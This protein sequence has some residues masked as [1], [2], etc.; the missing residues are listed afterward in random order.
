MDLILAVFLTQDI[1][2]PIFFNVKWGNQGRLRAHQCQNFFSVNYL[3]LVFL[4]VNLAVESAHLMLFSFVSI[5]IDNGYSAIQRLEI[6]LRA[7]INCAGTVDQDQTFVLFGTALVALEHKSHENLWI[8]I[9]IEVPYPQS[10]LERILFTCVHLDIKRVRN[11][12][13]FIILEKLLQVLN[14]YLV[15]TS[16]FNFLLSEIKRRENLGIVNLLWLPAQVLLITKFIIFVIFG[17]QLV[18]NGIN[19][20]LMVKN[21]IGHSIQI[22]ICKRY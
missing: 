19:L 16:I 12:D 10:P 22:D 4:M 11:I 7:K 17:N 13:N 5:W 1:N 21:H 15:S 2:F 20:L 14:G 8:A 18:V 6:L 9:N 3:S